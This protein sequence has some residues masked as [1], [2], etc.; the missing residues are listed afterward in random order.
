MFT[1]KNANFL[2]V[3][4]ALIMAAFRKRFKIEVYAL[5]FFCCLKFC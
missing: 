1:K 3:V 4:M 5:K 2:L